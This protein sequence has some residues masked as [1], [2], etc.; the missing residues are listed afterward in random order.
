M[1]TKPCRGRP[2]GA[3]A[4]NTPHARALGAAVRHLRVVLGKSQE[5]LAIQAEIE[6]SHM[7]KIERGEHLPSILLIAKIATAL[8]CGT[9]ELIQKMDEKLV[10]RVNVNVD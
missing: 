8:G 1:D 5:E 10:E 9:A 7:G 2:K 3:T 4:N 6:R